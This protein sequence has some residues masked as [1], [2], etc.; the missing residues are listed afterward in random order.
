MCAMSFVAGHAGCANHSSHP[1]PSVHVFFSR[2]DKPQQ[3][4]QQQL[5][6]TSQR[7]LLSPVARWVCALDDDENERVMAEA[8][9]KGTP[10]SGAISTACTA[11]R[12]NSRL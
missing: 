2:R 10:V 11:T 7:Q 4:H 5:I 3:Q 9:A 8:L 1:K 12:T 6:S